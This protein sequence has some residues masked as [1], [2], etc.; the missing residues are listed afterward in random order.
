MKMTL[1]P[2]ESEWTLDACTFFSKLVESESAVFVEFVEKCD[3]ISLMQKWLVNIVINENSVSSLLIEK[4]FAKASIKDST[5]ETEMLETNVVITH[6]L[7]VHG[8]SM[9]LPNN[10]QDNELEEN[11]EFHPLENFENEDTPALN[12]EDQVNLEIFKSNWP[13]I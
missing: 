1:F 11:Q 4:N 3:S 5:K 10:S 2:V 9:Q 8:E 12:S 6:T 7:T 13:K